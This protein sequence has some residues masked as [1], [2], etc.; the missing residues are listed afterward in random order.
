MTDPLA[1]FRTSNVSVLVDSAAL[2]VVA[3]DVPAVS[4]AV[5]APLVGGGGSGL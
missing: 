5:L 3:V 2:F 1:G 4:M